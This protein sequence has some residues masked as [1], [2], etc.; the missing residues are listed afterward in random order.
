MGEIY[1]CGLCGGEL[2]DD[3]GKQEQMSYKE[4]ER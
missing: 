1:K 4:V 3:G 2:V